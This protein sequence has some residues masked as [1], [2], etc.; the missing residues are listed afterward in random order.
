MSTND[1]NKPGEGGEAAEEGSGAPA[2][3]RL[4]QIL[5]GVGVIT[6]GRMLPDQWVKPVVESITLPAHAQTSPPD[7]SDDDDDDNDDNDDNDDL[8][9]P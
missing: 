8:D 9:G 3:R 1:K 2:R 7:D 4:L 5:L 6:S